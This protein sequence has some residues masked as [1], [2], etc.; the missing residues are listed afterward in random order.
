MLKLL[1]FLEHIQLSSDL[2]ILAWVSLA[3]LFPVFWGS[4]PEL[5]VCFTESEEGGVWEFALATV[6]NAC[7]SV[8]KPDSCASLD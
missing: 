1:Y 8:L 5:L 6:V 3:S 4:W 7:S 2:F